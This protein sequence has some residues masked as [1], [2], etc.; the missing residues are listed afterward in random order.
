MQYINHALCNKSDLLPSQGS[1]DLKSDFRTANFEG[2]GILPNKMPLN[3]RDHP[4]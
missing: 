1:N 2:D 3:N 4:Q